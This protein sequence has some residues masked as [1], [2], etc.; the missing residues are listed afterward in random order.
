MNKVDRLVVFDMESGNAVAFYEDQ[1]EAEAAF[2][3][4]AQNRPEEARDLVLVAYDKHGKTLSRTP[5][6]TLLAPA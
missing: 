5:G 4:A 1:R 2:R 6:A 3:K